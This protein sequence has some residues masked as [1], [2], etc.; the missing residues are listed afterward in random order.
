ME[1]EKKENISPEHLASFNKLVNAISKVREVPYGIR[2]GFTCSS[3]FSGNY[4]ID[5]I[6][7][8]KNNLNI[9]AMR[10]IS[11]FYYKTSSSYRRILNYFS[12]LYKYYYTLDLKHLANEY[13]ES[14]KESIKKIYYKTLDFLD[15]FNIEDTF[16]FIATRMLVDGAFYGY[17]N[18]FD[19]DRITITMLDPNYCITRF[20][21]PYNTNIVEFDVRFFNKYTD[22]KE[23]DAALNAFPDSVK[24]M[25]NRYNNGKMKDNNY[26]AILPPEQ[27]CAFQFGGVPIPP[28]FDTIIDIINFNDYKDIEKRRDTQELEK[29]LIQKFNLDEQGDLEVLLDEMA[30]MHEAVSSIFKDNPNIDVLT[31]IADVDL[32]DTQSSVGTS[33]N[34]NI[35]KMLVPK[36]ENAGISFEMFSSTTATSLE[37]SISNS[38]SFMSQAITSF[39]AWLSMVCLSHFKYKKIEPIVTILPLTWYNEKRLVDTYLKQAQSGYSLILP[40][41]ATGKKQS[42]ILDT[43]TLENTILELDKSLIPPQTS[44]TQSS[45][46][47]G[48][49]GA[50]QKG[51]IQEKADGPGR[52]EKPLEEKSE[53]TIKNINAG[54]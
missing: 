21:S 5:D 26:Y 6:N 51:D 40:Y 24:K 41:V 36:Y 45:D 25:W 2:Y 50:R 35:E 11:N 13:E 19:D 30:Q 1:N 28:F 23:L 4:S 39:S 34:N 27:S 29:I 38:T 10:E 18:F 53:K 43:K 12:Y 54:G 22:K 47:S 48:S 15:H 32:K 14:N 31:T 20:K 46:S 7:D 16:G 9:Q 33:T 52:P 44:Y 49:E 3:I 42:T 8:A 37:L 17:L